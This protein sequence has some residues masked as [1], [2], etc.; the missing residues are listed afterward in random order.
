MR[1]E[2]VVFF[3]QLNKKINELNELIENYNNQTNKLHDAIFIIRELKVELRKKNVKNSNTFLFF[4][5]DDVIVFT[6]KIFSDS[7]MF[8][9]EKNLIIDD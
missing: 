1:D 5:V 4:I 8:I 7:S 2:H 9:D 3:N 6:S